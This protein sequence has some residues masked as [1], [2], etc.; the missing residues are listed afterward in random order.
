MKF[1]IIILTVFIVLLSTVTGCGCD[2][3]DY[4]KAT[5]TR[6]VDG[7]T[8]RVDINGKEE[9]V[10][11]IG[12]DTPETVK[13]NHPV[14]PYGKEASEFTKKKLTGKTVYLETDLEERDRYQRLLAYVWLEKPNGINNQEIREKMFNAILLR[15]GYGQLLTVPPNVKY[16]D[17]FTEYQKEAR[18]N[19]RG[20]WG[21]QETDENNNNEPAAEPITANRYIGNKNTRKFHLPTCTSLD[22]MSEAN[23]V[24]F[25]ERQEALDANFVPC[26][27][28]KP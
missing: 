17:Y 23:K 3:S 15:E 14:E 26:G 11:L 16:S 12:V 18:E 2:S 28:C 25:N 5:V 13:P 27:N 7:D 4:I 22:K 1:R 21:L 20:L 8:I 19:N 6:V 9:A 24:Y 10:R